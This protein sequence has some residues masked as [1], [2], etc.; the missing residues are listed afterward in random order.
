MAESYGQIVFHVSKDTVIDF[1]GLCDA[2]NKQEWHGFGANNGCQNRLFNWRV[3]ESVGNG[4]ISLLYADGQ[5]LYWP[6]CIPLVDGEIEEEMALDDFSQWYAP[7]IT[8]GSFEITA[9]T[10]YQLFLDFDTIVC[11]A[12]GRVVREHRFSG[13]MLGCTRCE[14]QP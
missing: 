6:S 14:Y 13:S 9:M 11:Y 7:F 10:S 4:S 12:D 3:S 1:N 8:A 5:P 2:F